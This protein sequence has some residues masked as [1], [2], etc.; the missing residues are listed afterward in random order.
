MQL[1]TGQCRAGLQMPQCKYGIKENYSYQERGTLRSSL[2]PA[3]KRQQKEH[4]TRDPRREK[5]PKR[6]I[7]TWSEQ[8]PFPQSFVDTWRHCASFWSV[9]RNPLS[10]VPAAH[11]PWYRH[12]LASPVAPGSASGASVKK[13]TCSTS[14]GRWG[15]SFV[16]WACIHTPRS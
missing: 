5:N 2:H 15:A 7:Y 4:A 8:R 11:R 3:Q 6:D 12:Q 13:A 10:K 1:W 14:G 9:P 16:T